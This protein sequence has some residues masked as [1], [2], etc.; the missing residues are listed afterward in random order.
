NEPNSIVIDETAA[1]RYFDGTDIVGKTLELSNHTICKV[2][3]VIRNIPA[4]SHF[5]FSFIRPLRDY[6]NH[7]DENDWL[8]NNYTSFILVK[9]GVTRAFMQSRLNTMVNT[10]LG[11]QLQDLLHASVSDIEK[12]GNH[13]RYDLMPLTDIH[14]YS[15][16]SYEY[17][18]N[19]S[20][21]YVYVF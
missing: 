7:G 21:T 16:K 11:R 13:F 12:S 15:N 20:A 8:S 6:Y 3:G 19:G 2:T 17:E 14:L 1:K 5:H 9:P 18:A 10:Y 4:Q